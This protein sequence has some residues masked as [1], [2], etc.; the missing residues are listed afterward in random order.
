MPACCSWN[1]VLQYETNKVTR[2]QS[3]NY[4]TIK[5]V[6][7]VM[8]FSYVSFALVSDKLYQRKE[9]VISSVHTKVKGIAK[10]TENVMEGGVMKSL[11]SVFDTADYTFPLQGNSFFVMTNFLKSEG[12]EQ[13]LCPE[14]PTS[15]SALCKSD[16]DCK[17][18]WMDAQ[19]KE[20]NILALKVKFHIYLNLVNHTQHA[21]YYKENNVEKR[22]LIKAFGIRFDILV[23]GTGGKFDII[24]L[25]VY[26][27]S[28]LSYFGLATVFIDL[29]INT[30]SSAF[31]R[32]GVYPYCKCCEVCAVN[33]YYY[34][35]KC[36]LVVEPK[37]RPQMDVMDLSRLSLS[38]HDSPP[39]PGQPEEMQLLCKEV[40]PR[41][42]DSPGWCQCGNCFPS[43]LPENRRALEELCCR[44]KPGP[45]I[46]TSELFWKL[47]L[48]RQ[49]LQ[50]LL[51]YQEPLLVLEEEA[52]NR[53]LRHCAYR[54]Y[55]IWRFGSQDMAN[56]A[57]L[58]SCCR[59][60]IRKEFP[61][62]EGQYSG[63]KWVFVWEKGYQETDS[64]VSSV[65][66]KAKGVAVTNTS[67]LGFR[68]WDVADYV[69]PAQEE[70]SL[71]IMTNMIITVNQTQSTCAEI[72]DKTTICDSDSN[73]TMGST[74]TH[75]NGIGTGKCVPFNES[76]KTCEVA[77]WCP[78]EN[79]ADVP[80][81]AFLKAAE[82]FTLLVKNNIWYPKFNFSKRNILPNITTSYLKS[83][84]YDARTDPFCP[85]FRLGKIVEDAGHSFQDMAVEGGI[86]GIQVK[87]D[88]NLDRAASLC[89]PRYS[90]RRLD[91]RDL[92]HN[93]SPGYNFRFAKYYKDL[94]GNEQRTLIK[95][96]GI[97][98][99]I[100]VFG[101]AGK[102][103]II[104]TMINI[105]S[106]L[107]LLGVAT[108]LCDVI[109][110]YCMKKR[111]YYRDKKYKY[112]EDYEQ[113]LAGEMSQ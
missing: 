5:W 103:D 16:R 104:P 75:S 99:D 98:F 29:I 2:I 110:L 55:T 80:T 27:G 106:G 67:E 96:Y 40:A 33:E 24:Q 3:M 113:G 11:H 28:T 74:G 43:R 30:Y 61:K 19:S 72:P 7:H 52:T 108:V 18:G 69:I 62:T 71:F 44:R 46:T 21:K 23:F 101:K 93:V 60:R 26:I 57:I 39:I 70:N 81:P 49:A 87:W 79:D 109:V 14:F 54:C 8:V 97:R 22:T 25:V 89:L 32:S 84:I 68:I 94:T 17:E 66:T 48:S 31:C 53:R 78:V 37:P 111:Y 9:P 91:T 13:K 6:L 73:C 86:M 64:V 58:P 51:L 10:V 38:L 107:A 76:V 82:N 35:K 15:R 59:W 65:T 20:A 95:A 41:S 100:I 34:R 4:G 36:E 105:G 42:G 90:F 56:F 45:C 102:F 47:V 1:D 112:V 88:C 85:I 63:F 12:Q 83:C 50:L 77:A 92:E